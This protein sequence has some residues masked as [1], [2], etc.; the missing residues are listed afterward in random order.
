MKAGRRLIERDVVEALDSAL[1][2]RFL[3]PWAAA[4][5][6]AGSH[7]FV[8]TTDPSAL[9][10][11]GTTVVSTKAKST[12]TGQPLGHVLIVRGAAVR[13]VGGQSLWSEPVQVLVR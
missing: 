11:V 2:G 1:L 6:G 3:V 4:V 7:V 5:P 12:V 8:F 13:K 10:S 9:P